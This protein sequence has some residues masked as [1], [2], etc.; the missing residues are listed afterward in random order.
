MLFLGQHFPYKG[1]KELLK[2]AP[3]VWQRCPEAH[4][5]FIGPPVGDSERYFNTCRRAYPAR[6]G[7]YGSKPR[8]MPLPH[9][10]VLCVP[11]TQESF[12]GVYTEAWSF[13]KPV[14]GCP[15]PAV[16]RSY[17]HQVDGLLVQQNPEAIADAILDLLT[18][19]G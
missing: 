12:G 13:G 16:Q 14:I 8:P 17:R 9:V 5:V 6:S 15:I 18:S 11:S 10:R 4:F 2:A 7:R 3:I 1:F 19:R